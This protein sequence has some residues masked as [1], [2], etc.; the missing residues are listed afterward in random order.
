MQERASI[1]A[2]PA[3][4][5]VSGPVAEPAIEVIPYSPR[6]TVPMTVHIEDRTVRWTALGQLST[7]FYVFKSGRD[8]QEFA[9]LLC[10]NPV[11]A[12]F[13]ASLG[14]W[15]TLDLGELAFRYRERGGLSGVLTWLEEHSEQIEKAVE[16]T[17]Y[18]I[19][20]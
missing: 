17:T 7:D 15:T 2:E 1:T 20:G 4:S 5:R 8:A 11:D 3:C 14:Q 18:Q 6:T 10:S 9:E 12:A 19:Q 16:L 13:L